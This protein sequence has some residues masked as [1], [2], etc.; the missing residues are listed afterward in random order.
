MTRRNMDDGCW[1]ESAAALAD[2]FEALDDAVAVFDRDHRLTVCNLSFTLHY[3]ATGLEW[4]PGLAW[5]VFFGGAAAAGVGQG[6]EQVDQV[7]KSGRLRALVVEA[8]RPD[9]TVVRIRL[10][11]AGEGGFVLAEADVTEDRAGE[12]LRAEA[13]SLLRQVLDACASSIFMSRIDDGAIF[14]QTPQSR[15][16]FGEVSDARTT[17][18]DRHERARYLAELLP[19]GAVDDFEVMLQGIGGRRFPASVSG[20]LV[21]YRGEEVL[22]SSIVDTTAA[23]AQRQENERL[24]QRLLDA[25]EALSEAFV[26]YD[27]D[28]R[29]VIANRLFRMLHAPVAALIRPGVAHA[30]VVEAVERASL[31]G[32]AGALRS[33][34]GEALAAG[35]FTRRIEVEIE[36]RSGRLYL[37]SAAPTA[38]GGVVETWR[39]ITDDRRAEEAEREADELVRTIVASS[40]TT[41]LVSRVTD[42]KIV[43]ISPASRARFG[44]IDSALSFFLDPADRTRYLE[45]LLPTGQLDNY[46]VRF[47]RRDGSIMEGLTS[48]RVVDYKGEAIIVSSTRDITDQLAMEAELA[49]QREIAHQNEKL[50]ALGAL[51]AGWR[52]SS[53]I[54]CR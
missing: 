27:C 42:G 14:Y 46:R 34:F 5:S 33:A 16:L 43:Y 3:A 24:N 25:I 53:T 36:H 26:L 48:A 15:L 50:S 39:D 32:N 19:T 23:K 28:D 22:V 9:A 35:R 49:R 29:L 6:L 41:F 8:P 21:D 4:Q 18:V 45:A 2:A 54:R 31:S 7:L 52:T 37:V 51:L 30:E 47:R 1:V 38:E 12:E 17:Y 13:D 20:R 44:E 11:P 40:P 10:R